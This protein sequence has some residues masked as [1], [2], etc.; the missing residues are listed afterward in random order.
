MKVGANLKYDIKVYDFLSHCMSMKRIVVSPG[1]QVF[2]I[3]L[4]LLVRQ[5]VFPSVP[6]SCSGPEYH[7]F[8]FWIG[9]WNAFDFDNPAIV[10]GRTKVTPILS[11]CV[12]HEEYHGAD[13]HEGESFSVYDATRKVWHQSWVTNRGELLI[14]EGKFEDGAMTLSGVQRMMDGKDKEIR[15]VWKSVP[16]GVRETAVTSI[17]GGKTW[18]PWFDIVFRQR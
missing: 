14:I 13:G 3:A 4:V 10:T 5:Q 8:D 9:D 15:G 16:T 17:D 1:W 18:Q 7:Q 2:C 6:T 12:L 11:G